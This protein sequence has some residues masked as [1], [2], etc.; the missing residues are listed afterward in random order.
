MASPLISGAS[1]QKPPS[2]QPMAAFVLEESVDRRLVSVIYDVAVWTRGSIVLNVERAGNDGCG[3]TFAQ[4]IAWTHLRV[5]RW[6]ACE[7]DSH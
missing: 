1:G 6:I 2:S 5:L 7:V 4:D 3:Q